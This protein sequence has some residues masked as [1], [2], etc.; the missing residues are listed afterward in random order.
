MG[1][2]RFTVFLLYIEAFHFPHFRD[3][4]RLYNLDVFE[5]EL[6]NTMALYVAVPYILAAKANRGTGALWLVVVFLC[7]FR[8]LF[9]LLL[10]LCRFSSL[11]LSLLFFR[12]SSV[13]FRLNAAETWIDTQSSEHSTGMFRGMLNKVFCLFL[14]FS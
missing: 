1:E 11:F 8:L 10:F 2:L 13:F 5:Y 4:F 14:C 9:L 3:P 7:L 6:H 12:F